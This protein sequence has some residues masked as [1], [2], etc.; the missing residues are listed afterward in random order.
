MCPKVMVVDDE[1]D[2]IELVKLVLE[3]EG[4]NVIGVTSGIKC[5]ETLDIEKPDAILLDIMMPVMDGWETFR[6]IKKKNPNIPVSMLTVKNQHFDR[7]L[8]LH[9]LKADDYITKPFGKNELTERTKE[10]IKSRRPE[11]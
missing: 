2:T 6:K 9:L 5:L 3:S 4:I 10:L 8:G 1:K 11:V 7:M